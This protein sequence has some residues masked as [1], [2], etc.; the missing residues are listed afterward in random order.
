LSKEDPMKYL[1]KN[2]KSFTRQKTTFYI[3]WVEDQRV[4]G[5]V[6]YIWRHQD[7]EKVGEIIGAYQ[8]IKG[9]E[10]ILIHNN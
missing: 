3:K 10:R 5:S 9:K 6:R 8:L 2:L 4:K 7:S 1:I